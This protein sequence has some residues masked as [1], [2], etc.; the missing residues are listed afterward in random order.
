VALID[1]VASASLVGMRYA[2]QKAPTTTS[3]VAVAEPTLWAS[4]L[5]RL[6]VAAPF[7]YRVSFALVWLRRADLWLAIDRFHPRTHDAWRRQ[8][9]AHGRLQ[10]GRG[11]DAARAAISLNA[12]WLAELDM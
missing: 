5:T 11:F 10:L 8:P 3:P 6:G 1:L 9:E 7:T 4:T 2:G 12:S